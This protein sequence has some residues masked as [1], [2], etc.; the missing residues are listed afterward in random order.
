MCILCVTSKGFSAKDTFC[1][2]SD[3]CWPS[4]KEWQ[5]LKAQVG[6][7]LVEPVEST[8]VCSQ[9][10]RSH[11]CKR[12]LQDIKNPFFL[13]SNPGDTQSQGWLGAWESVASQYAV[14]AESSEDVSYALSFAKKH[15]LKVV[16]KGAGHDYLGRNVAKDSLLIW[17]RPIRKLEYQELFIP[18]GAPRQTTPVKAIIVGAGERWLEVYNKVTTE[19]QRYVQGGGCTSVGAIG[20]FTQGG[21]FGSWSKKFGTGAA[22]VLELKIVTATGETLIANP[23][24]NKELFWAV[25]GGGGGT[26]GVVT[27]MSLRTHP[28]PKEFALV[29]GEIKAH[30]EEGYSL[31]VKQVLSFFQERLNNEHWGENISFS[32]KKIQWF[33]L[34]QGLTKEDITAVWKSLK[35]FVDKTPKE[36]QMSQNI[37]MIPPKKMWDYHYMN[38]HFPDLVVKNKAKG[39]AQNEYWWQPNSGEVSTFWYTYQSWWLPESLFKDENLAN[40]AATFVKVSKEHPFAFHIQ[41]GLA[42]A[43]SEAIALSR[44]TST[45]PGVYQASGLLIMSAG[46]DKIIPGYNEYALNINKAQHEVHA[47]NKA[48]AQIKSLAPKAGTYANEADYFQKN[49]QES[50]WGSNYPKLLAIKKKIDPNGL[51]RCHHCVGS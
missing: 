33:L 6:G 30:T 10:P 39:A 32:D 7:R 43:S 41:K 5:K 38:T 12:A 37:T 9:K 21:G 27:E 50:F 34:S 3:P 29:R 24:Q 4:T 13:Q 15:H 48:M 19:N 49:W 17:V 46:T 36:Y 47:I 23:Y 51:F 35:D 2:P 18:Q 44:Q 20:G 25:R 14:L 40:T 16:V 26:F 42:G 31:L 11:A 1:Q 22:G 8:K 28:L 45:H